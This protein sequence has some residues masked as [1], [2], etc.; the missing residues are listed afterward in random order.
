MSELLV[1]RVAMLDMHDMMADNIGQTA[2]DP[3]NVAF[4]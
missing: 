4:W 2:A 1:T 3:D